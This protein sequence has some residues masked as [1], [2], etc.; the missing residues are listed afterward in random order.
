[1]KPVFSKIFI[2]LASVGSVGLIVACGSGGG[3]S[4]NQEQ[5][6]FAGAQAATGGSLYDKYGGQPTIQKVVDDA[7]TGVLADP[8]VAP[9]FG[10]I[11][12]PGHDSADRLKSCLDL[13][14]T[15]LFGGPATYPGISHFRSAPPEGY[16]CED[17]RAAHNGLNIPGNVFDKFVADL[18]GVM[19]AD[20][21]SDADIATLAP[22][23]AAIRTP[24]VNNG[25]GGDVNTPRGDNSSA[26]N[27]GAGAGQDQP[28]QDQPKQDQPKQAPQKP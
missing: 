10:F 13:Q 25:R 3:P 17:M 5:P 16:Q 9:F 19:K 6:Q 2:I 23:L 4:G 11:G 8:V 18:T 28:K 26:G 20:G 1:M 12:Q 7:V 15:A 14:F 22:Q 24:T 21:V 27:T